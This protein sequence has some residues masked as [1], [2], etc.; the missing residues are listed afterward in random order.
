[1]RALLK[2]ICC[3]ARADGEERRS[4]QGRAGRRTRFQESLS[5][6]TWPFSRACVG[7]MSSKSAVLLPCDALAVNLRGTD[8]KLARR[9][10]VFAGLAATIWVAL[11]I[12]SIVVPAQRN[13]RDA[14][15][16]VPFTLTL[17]AFR[18]M[19]GLQRSAGVR[20]ECWGFAATILSMLLVMIGN[21]GVVADQSVL[22]SSHSRLGHCCGPL[23]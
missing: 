20:L 3:G 22:A 23:P 8:G 12:E 2:I 15:W 21:I 10:G 13:Y 4:R 7:K 1:M 19:H 18:Y 17:V 6:M 5:R 11:G 16:F 14:L 9:G